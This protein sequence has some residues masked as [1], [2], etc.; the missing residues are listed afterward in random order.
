LCVSDGVFVV[1]FCSIDSLLIL[2][3]GEALHTF[4]LENVTRHSFLAVTQHFS[5]F[6]YIMYWVLMMASVLTLR[7]GLIRFQLS[8]HFWSIITIC[9]VV[10][11]IKYFPDTTLKGIFWFFFPMSMVIMNDVSAYFIGSFFGKKFIQAPFLALSPNKTWEGF[12]GAFFCTVL[13][14]FFFS[15]YLAQ[16]TWYTCPA[17]TLSASIF[18]DPLTCVPNPVF[19]VKD[20]IL[21]VIGSVS[22]YPVQW[23]GLAY[24]F[25]ASIVAPFGGFFASALKR[26][27]RKK[28]FDSF[29]PGHGGVMDRMDCQLVMFTFNSFYHRHFI[30]PLAINALDNI[31]LAAAK[32][33]SE[34]QLALLKEVRLPLFVVHFVWCVL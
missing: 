30:A 6:G 4:C 18:H 25:F 8:Q 17:E 19:V 9:I 23:H 34:D 24:G 15:G 29:F 7:P 10:L 13:F 2:S 14:S 3:D 16:F 28:D 11:Q 21:P 27:Y 26:A 32:L 12:I 1:G 22:L 33:S 31:L 5:H 20:Y